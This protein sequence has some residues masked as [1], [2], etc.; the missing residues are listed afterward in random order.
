MRSR[1]NFPEVWSNLSP[2]FIPFEYSFLRRVIC[3]EMEEITISIRYGFQKN[4]I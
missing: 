3:P 2:V 4:S 1:Q